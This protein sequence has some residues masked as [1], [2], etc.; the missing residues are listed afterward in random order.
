VSGALGGLL[1]L[2]LVIPVA[3]IGVIVLGLVA[4]SGG[5]ESDPTGVRQ[6]SAYLG[7]ICFVALFT[8]LFGLFLGTVEIAYGV[9]HTITTATSTTY[10]FSPGTSGTDSTGGT[11]STTPLPQTSQL[12]STADPN[13]AKRAVSGGIAGAIVFLVGAVVFEYHRRRIEVIV[14]DDHFPFS[15]ARR[16]IQ[17][18]VYAVAFVS[19]LVA[20]GAGAVFLYS[21]VRMAAPSLT[22]PGADGERANA[23]RAL[24]SS[25]VLV[26]GAG[27]LFWWHIRR[28]DEWD[29]RA[30]ALAPAPASAQTPA[31]PAPEGRPRPRPRPVACSPV[32]AAR[33][34]PRPRRRGRPRPRRDARLRPRRPRPLW[35]PT[36]SPAGAARPRRGAVRR[37]RLS[38]TVR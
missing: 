35:R 12:R 26:F 7:A 25:G 30:A 5:R 22:A 1:G 18:Y 38:R 6:R 24:V 3:L 36:P 11:F 34:S 20:L 16:G 37:I 14:A 17:A 10:S 28:P 33:P 4:A 8:M 32:P 31:A 13:A 21:L 27:G 19:A 15:P 23:F 9:G 29:A 2:A